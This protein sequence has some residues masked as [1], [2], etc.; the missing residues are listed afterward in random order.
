[1][2]HICGIPEKPKQRI[3]CKVRNRTAL[4]G[5]SWHC[6]AFRN[7]SVQTID[8]KT[9]HTLTLAIFVICSGCNVQT[10]TQVASN[11][12]LVADHDPADQE[13]AKQR[14]SDL[15]KQFQADL[16]S[17]KEK[18]GTAKSESVQQT[19]FAEHDPLPGYIADLIELSKNYCETPTAVNATLEVIARSKGDQKDEQMKHL[20]ETFP[21][22]LDYGKIIQSL[23][24]DAPSSEIEGWLKLMIKHAPEGKMRATAIMGFTTYVK[25]LPEYKRAFKNNPIVLAKLPE[26]QQQYL[27][28]ERTPEQ[29]AE[30]VAYLNE[31]IEKYAGIKYQRGVTFDD[32]AAS[33]LREFENLAIGKPAPELVG[34]DLDGIE[35]KLSD[36]QGKIIMLDFWGHWCGPCRAMYPEERELVQRLSGTPFVLIGMN[37][38]HSLEFAKDAVEREGLSWRHFWNGTEGTRGPIAKAWNIDAWPTVYLIDGQG[39][40]RYKDVLGKDLT[41]A[42]E[43]L[44]AE[45]GHQIDLSD[46]N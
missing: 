12:G 24:T 29:D 9:L 45:A 36:Y 19:I 46:L 42:L 15:Q 18:I 34:K 7:R 40:I 25:N 22:K 21:T 23:Y 4:L 3:Y 1:M 5:G 43:N 37:S 13:S 31:V 26:T 39:T 33:D 20:I 17:L 8:M 16:K 27:L 32:S 10:D 28:S 35:F 38:D 11:S 14:Y 2:P 6:L 41:K 30:M 44:L